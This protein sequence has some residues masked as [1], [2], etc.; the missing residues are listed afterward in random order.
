MTLQHALMPTSHDREDDE[1]VDGNAIS[2]ATVYVD[3]LGMNLMQLQL[4]GVH[5][6]SRLYLFRR[7]LQYQSVHV[8]NTQDLKTLKK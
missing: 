3:V 4:S 6:Y 2:P 5:V 8:H 7:S 1:C